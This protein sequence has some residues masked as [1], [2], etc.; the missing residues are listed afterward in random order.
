MALTAAF[1]RASGSLPVP[2]RTW[3]SMFEN[4]LSM[5]GSEGPAAC[6]AVFTEPPD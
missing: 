3:L 1:F 5:P 6:A 4:G 2:L